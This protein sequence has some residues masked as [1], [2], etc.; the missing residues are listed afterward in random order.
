MI[1]SNID[2]YCEIESLNILSRTEFDVSHF[3][4]QERDVFLVFNRNNKKMI[5]ESNF[6]FLRWQ[7]SEQIFKKKEV[8]WDEKCRLVQINQEE[9]KYSFAFR[10]LFIRRRS[11]LLR[12]VKLVPAEDSITCAFGMFSNKPFHEGQWQV[13]NCPPHKAKVEVTKD[14]KLCCK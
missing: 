1:A 10:F 8:N 7:E 13:S 3:F 14:V 9:F 5:S 6:L 4:L 11:N 2:C 12:N